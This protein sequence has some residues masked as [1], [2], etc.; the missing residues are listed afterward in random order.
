[1]PALNLE[2][3]FPYQDQIDIP[4]MP[5]GYLE[6]GITWPLSG[7]VPNTP[8]IVLGLTRRWPHPPWPEE[9]AST[10]GADVGD[11]GKFSDM[12]LTL[13]NFDVSHIIGSV[14]DDSIQAE[15]SQGQ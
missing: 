7:Y 9:N 3:L 12:S 4:P 14:M 11:K 2:N 10:S 8:E 5:E 6:E 1:V 13:V 15:D